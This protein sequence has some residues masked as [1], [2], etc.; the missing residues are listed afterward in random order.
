MTRIVRLLTKPLWQEDA[1]AR[2][3]R[4]IRQALVTP[5][6]TLAG[7]IWGALAAPAPTEVLGWVAGGALGFSL[8]GYLYFR[9]EP[10]IQHLGA[11]V[12][13]GLGWTVGLIW[14][15]IV[16]GGVVFLVTDVLGMPTFEA[17]TSAVLIGGTYAMGLAWFFDDGGSR[18]LSGFLAGSWGRRRVPFSHIESKI[19][20]GD[21]DGAI[22]ALQDH[23]MRHPRDARGWITLGRL[24]DKERDDPDGA[25]AALRDGLEVARLTLEQK[26]RYLHEVVRVC[27]S[28]GALDR[29]VPL[30][31]SYRAEHE[32]TIQADWADAQLRRIGEGAEP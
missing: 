4:R 10:A 31:M 14:D 30:L 25:F 22:E 19:A 17:V 27:R 6:M 2:R 24:L 23:V 7:I 3:T 16:I 15:W 13:G 28:C 1:M 20:G 32:G 5:V 9:L 18:A 21:V 11:H 8:M 12:F 26:Q 29:A